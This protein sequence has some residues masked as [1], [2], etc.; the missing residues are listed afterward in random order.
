MTTYFMSW[1]WS[2]KDKWDLERV[3]QLQLVLFGHVTL[4]HE[5]NPE[6]KIKIIFKIMNNLWLT[7]VIINPPIPATLQYGYAVCS[8]VPKSS[9]VP[10]PAIPVLEA[11][12]V[13]PYS[14][15]ALSISWLILVHFA[16]PR[17]CFYHMTVVNFMGTGNPQVFPQVWVQDSRPV[18]N[19]YP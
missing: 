18:E 19:P 13:N 7:F 11:L 15:A 5:T 8:G 14:W 17:A 9:T 4:R 6:R 12:W 1:S 3:M 2:D 16:W 10:V